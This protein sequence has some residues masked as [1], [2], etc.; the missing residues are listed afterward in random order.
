MLVIST[1]FRLIV[2]F[3]AV[4]VLVGGLSLAVGTRVIYRAVLKEAETR[5]GQDLNTARELYLDRERTLLLALTLLQG[6]P[7]FRAA[8]RGG[9]VPT[10]SRRL[11]GLA[12]A[13]AVDFAGVLGSDGRVLGRLG[14]ER[15]SAGRRSNPAVQLALERGTPVS[16]TVVLEADELAAESPLLA[17]R[18]RIAILPTPRA[19]PRA[20]AEETAGLALAAA[21]PIGDSDPP[22]VLYAG[23]LL[24][25]NEEIVDRIRDTVFRGETWQGQ[26]V[27]S[28]TI[29]FRDLR[30]AT[31]VPGPAGQRAV[32]TRVSEEVKRRVLDEGGR[33][34]DRAFVV[35]EWYLTAYE[36]IEDVLGRRVGIL[37]VGT[38]EAPYAGIRR[39]AL[40]VFVPITL[41]GIVLA[42]ALGDQLGLWLL[43]PVRRLI[44]ASH[45][46]ADGKLDVDLGPPANGEIGV[47][48]RTFSEMTAAL[49]QRDASRET[50]QEHQLAQSEKQASV[51]R[52]AAGIAHEI[53]NPL[54][55]VLTFTHMLLRR[56]DLDADARHDLETIAQSTER[57]RTIVKGL[58]D[59]ARQT[60][61][62]PESA[63]INDVVRGAL[64]LAGNQSLLKGVRLCFDPAHMLPPV[65][66]DRNQIQ[67]VLLNLLLNALDATEQGGHVTVSTS[68]ASSH[69]GSTGIEIEVADTGCGISPEHLERIF[70]PFYTTK[71]VGR[72]TGLGLSVSLGIVG[73][74]GGTIR[75]HSRPGQGSTFTVWLPLERE[76]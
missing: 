17:E 10:V 51:G 46:I 24:N 13:V 45:Q 27:G 32:G 69:A 12:D 38:R 63:D 49:R 64:A 74:H 55:G 15:P 8:L 58:L 34:I 11:G 73:R 1:R 19:A 57:V 43:R 16:G 53:N 9:D 31:N 60:R 61:L 7:G 71:E 72:G 26:I 21:V 39:Q 3:L 76:G 68:F 4:S 36:P 50:E 5:V 20:D 59:F 67:S 33:W 52:L 42:I 44:A 25:R 66:L 65:T 6:E 29:F 47:L 23:V 30:I 35:G 62:A 2:S 40:L 54:T 22:A 70:D 37:F 56:G 14:P 18:A 75:V 48:Q 41:A 28:A